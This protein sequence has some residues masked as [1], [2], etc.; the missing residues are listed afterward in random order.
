[1]YKRTC[2]VLLQIAGLGE[3]PERVEDIIENYDYT[4]DCF[5]CYF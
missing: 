1:M 5:T 3:G 2:L 4:G